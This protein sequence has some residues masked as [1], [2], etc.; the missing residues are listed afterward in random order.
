MYMFIDV[1][2]QFVAFKT[3]TLVSEHNKI[4]QFLFSAPCFWGVSM[5]DYHRS[6]VRREGIVFNVTSRLLNKPATAKHK[7]TSVPT[8]FV[9]KTLNKPE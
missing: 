6:K 4:E 2:Q 7:S 3:Y 8:T 1:A 5:P 9:K